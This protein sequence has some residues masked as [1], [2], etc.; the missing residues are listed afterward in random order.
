MDALQPSWKFSALTFALLGVSITG[1]A[2]DNA[3][4]AT[5]EPVQVLKTLK[6]QADS[7]PNKNNDISA[8]AKTIIN[9]ET[10]ELL[11]A[12]MV[13][14]EVTEHIQ[15]FAIAKYLEATDDSLAQVIFPHPTLSEA[16]HESILSA[17]QRAIHI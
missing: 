8:I 6:L 4:V 2:A 3:Q 7:S 10:G 11:G 9:R 14:H 17:M 1:W 16:M 5:A 13:G 15:G 12:H